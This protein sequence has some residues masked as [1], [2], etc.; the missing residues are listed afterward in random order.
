MLMEIFKALYPQ[1]EQEFITKDG[2]TQFSVI[3][4]HIGNAQTGD[5]VAY[6][7]DKT[8]LSSEARLTCDREIADAASSGVGEMASPLQTLINVRNAQAE[9]SL[10]RLHAELDRGI[11]FNRFD[12]DSRVQMIDRG[13]PAPLGWLLSRRAA[14]EL[15]L[16]FD[17]TARPDDCK[18][19]RNAG[20]S[21][22]LKEI[23][24]VQT[25]RN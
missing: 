12:F 13:I 3:A 9:Y 17:R 20:N 24:D 10:E 19:L 7:A 4:L 18:G 15:R 11:D 22:Q 1:R 16:Q 23:A 8:I 2:S 21:R 14:E 6:R 5:M 25:W